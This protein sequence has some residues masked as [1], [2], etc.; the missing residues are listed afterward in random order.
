MRSVARTSHSISGTCG[1]T[2]CHITAAIASPA[3]IRPKWA[4][5]MNRNCARGRLNS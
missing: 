4:A 2:R 1:S 3:K 5:A